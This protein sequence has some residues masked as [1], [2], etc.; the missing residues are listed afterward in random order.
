MAT[1]ARNFIRLCLISLALGFLLGIE[2]IIHPAALAYRP[3][4]AHLL[5]LGFMANMVFGVGYHILPRFQGHVTIPDMWASVHLH[6]AG[7]GLL[8]MIVGWFARLKLIDSPLGHLL[9]VGGL[10]ECVGV[11][12]FVTIIMK[13]LVPNK[14]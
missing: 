11:L 9:L 5:L 8:A 14:P 3:I 6:L 1:Y 2:M 12:I 13:G 4:H 10:A 7:W